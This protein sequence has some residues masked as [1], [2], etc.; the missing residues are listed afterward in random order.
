MRAMSCPRC[1]IPRCLNAFPIK[2]APFS[3]LSANTIDCPSTLPRATALT[4]TPF[5]R[6][7]STPAPT[8]T[9]SQPSA[10]GLHGW[11][12]KACFA[13]KK[14]AA[15]TLL[16]RLEARTGA[17]ALSTE[18]ANWHFQKQRD[19]LTRVW[20]AM[21]EIGIELETYW[22]GRVALRDEEFPGVFEVQPGLYGLMFFNAWGNLMAPLMG[23]LLAASL[24]ADRPDAAPFPMTKPRAVENIST[25]DRIIRRLLIPSARLGQAMGL[26]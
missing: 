21:R 22:T 20:P 10:Q 23:K 6:A 14:W 26:L 8:E 18:D 15:P 1:A 9:A 12:S 16:A 13:P 24:A 3:T 7:I 11:N 19:W 25:Q 5:N 2:A 17:M 4:A